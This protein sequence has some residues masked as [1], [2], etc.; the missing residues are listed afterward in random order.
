MATIRPAKLAEGQAG[1]NLNG[2]PGDPFQCGILV[3]D[4]LNRVSLVTGAAGRLLQIVGPKRRSRSLEALPSSIQ[5]LIAEAR[6]GGKPIV[7]RQIELPEGSH[8]PHLLRLSVLPRG[9]SGKVPE[10]TVVVQDLTSARL[11]EQKLR[12]LSRL[13]SLGLFSASLAHE[14]KNALV[15]GKTFFDLLLEKHRD[16]ELVELV[17]RE[18]A[19][20]DSLVSRMLR[21]TRP[22]KPTSSEVHLHDVLNHCLRLVE[23]QLKDK[24]IHLARAFAAPCDRVR[25]DDGQ[26]EQAFVNILLNA[27]EAMGPNG[28]LTVATEAHSSAPVRRARGASSGPA[29][30]RITIEDT[31]MGIPPENMDR[32]FGPFFTTKHGGTGLGLSITRRIIEEHG[33]VISVKSEPAQGAAFQILLPSFDSKGAGA[34]WEARPG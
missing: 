7:E 11:F 30:L 4:A 22:S 20:I 33:G 2:G 6:S 25:G 10:V 32:L 23:G 28:R 18:L 1:S 15:V 24:R 17:R 3:V 14:I 27:A 26:L 8:G 9:S 29:Q 12:Q 16:S 5:E 19:R 21:Y 34:D 31:G 13:A